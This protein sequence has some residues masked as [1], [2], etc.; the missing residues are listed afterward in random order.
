MG[1]KERLCQDCKNPLPLTARYNARFCSDCI[2]RHRREAMKAW[3]DKNRQRLTM[4][5]LEEY[6]YY[7]EHGICVDCHQAAADKDY[8]TCTACRA[9]RN[10]RSEKYYKKK[11]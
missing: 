4:E 9:K 8:T 10:K 6:Y 11:T 1:M 2:R 7:K 3:R 5:D